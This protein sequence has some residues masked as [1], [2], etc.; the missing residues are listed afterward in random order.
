MIS[1]GG[2][3]AVLHRAHPSCLHLSGHLDHGAGLY[4]HSPSCHQ[5]SDACRAAFV[6]ALSGLSPFACRHVLE[7]NV[8]PLTFVPAEA[9]VWGM[10]GGM[11]G[12]LLPAAGE[13]CPAVLPAPFAVGEDV[14]ANSVCCASFCNP[15]EQV[16]IARPLPGQIAPVRGCPD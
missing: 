10:A 11:S 14:T 7:Y 5:T 4:E 2:Q 8:T 9:C 16:H 12:F 13:A 1:E 15:P 3:L 6:L